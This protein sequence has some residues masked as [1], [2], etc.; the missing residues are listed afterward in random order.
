MNEIFDS[1][2]HKSNKEGSIEGNV[3]ENP[4][5]LLD[6]TNDLTTF[7]KVPLIFGLVLSI[8]IASLDNTI[9]ST[10]M[11]KI[12]S[13]FNALDSVTWV[14]GS[15]LLTSTAIQPLYGKISDIF[16]R[17]YTIL[18]ALFIFTVGSI[19]CGAAPNMIVL[20][21]FRAISG[22]GGGGLYSLSIII[23]SDLIP[24]R[25]RGIFIA[26]ASGIYAVASIVGPL[27]GG[28][29]SDKV[30]WRWAFYINIPICTITFIIVF[31][32]LNLPIPKGNMREKLGRVDFYG[33][34]TLM[35]FTI[36]LVLGLTWGGGEYEW[37][38]AAVIVPLVLA[39]LFLIAFIYVESKAVKEPI[40]PGR[41]LNRNT[42]SANISAFFVGALFMVSVY[43]LPIY[44]QVVR[45]YDATNS[46]LELLP[47][48]LGAVACNFVNGIIVTKTGKYRFISIIGGIFL[49]VGAALYGSLY[50]VNI[51]RAEEIIFPLIIGF[52]VGLSFQNSIMVVQIAS[53]DEDV[54]TSTSLAFFSN[55]LGSLVGLAI[56]GTIFNNYLASTLH[57]LL[58]ELDTKLMLSSVNMIYSLPDDQLNQVLYAYIQSF[59][60]LYLSMIPYAAIA[61]ITSLFLKHIPVRGHEKS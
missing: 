8:F 13:E 18:M 27:V 22:I 20:I 31:F 50:R 55:L 53:T 48:M 17:K 21:I 56:Q 10:A 25:I 54:A 6:S 11:A 42:I 36:C 40:V 41:V 26:I 49:I 23:I 32:F 28:A 33:A 35:L 44:Y 43:Y 59:R 24:P 14:A 12:V 47:L 30:T 60:I 57:Q 51:T 34:V 61:F 16:G 19:V 52:G 1:K 7:K 46:G 29:F 2:P 37:N 15:Y 3:I 5:D 9:I 58:P 45:N 4:E 38:S 39:G